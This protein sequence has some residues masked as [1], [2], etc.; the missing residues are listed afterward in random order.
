MQIE[1]LDMPTIFRQQQKY[2]LPMTGIETNITVVWLQKMFMFS[3]YDYYHVFPFRK[4][5]IYFLFS[6]YMKHKKQ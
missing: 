5:K 1:L 3:Y 6:K 4:K 2:T